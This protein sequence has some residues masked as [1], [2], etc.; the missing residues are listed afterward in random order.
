M[1]NRI[2][3]TTL[4]LFLV[5]CW[6]G[7]GPKFPDKNELGYFSFWVDGKFW[8]PKTDMDILLPYSSHSVGL[9][10]MFEDSIDGYAKIHVKAVNKSLDSYINFSADSILGEG[11]YS[12][13]DTIKTGD[14]KSHHDIFKFT[15]D[16][17]EFY[18]VIESKSWI[19]I[20]SMSNNRFNEENDAIYDTLKASFQIGCY[21]EN[22]SLLLE[23]GY[24]YLIIGRTYSYY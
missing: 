5:S 13:S 3:I 23:Y 11:I 24:F 17:E 1:K 9:V 2:L 12:I 15:I 20:E 4:L 16:D 10:P 7:G 21:N 19:K 6:D 22:N 14:N 18:D 8:Y